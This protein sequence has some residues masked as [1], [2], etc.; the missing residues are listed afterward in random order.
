MHLRM[1]VYITVKAIKVIMM[2]I[3]TLNN[4]KLM[5]FFGTSQIK[6]I[7]MCKRAVSN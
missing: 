4:L 1:K 7:A 5:I 3:V 2:L 6:G